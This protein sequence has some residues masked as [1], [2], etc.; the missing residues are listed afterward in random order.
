MFI[1]I[2]E[3]RK[4][5]F[6]YFFIERQIQEISDKSSGQSQYYHVRVLLGD[7]P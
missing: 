5:S 2:C 4:V 7:G 3:R 1:L 6:I